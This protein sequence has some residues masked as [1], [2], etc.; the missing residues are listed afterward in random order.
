MNEGL[1]VGSS[2]EIVNDLGEDYIKFTKN[3]KI[4]GSPK[5]WIEK[6]KCGGYVSENKFRNISDVDETDDA[7]IV[8]IKNKLIEELHQHDD[9]RVKNGAESTEEDDVKERN[10]NCENGPEVNNNKQLFRM[11]TVVM[12]EI[13]DMFKNPDDGINPIFNHL[14]QQKENKEKK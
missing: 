12:T 4:I 6:T 3:T 8:S 2:D 13:Q 1:Y 5:T 7:E 11:D 10:S 9:L 14:I